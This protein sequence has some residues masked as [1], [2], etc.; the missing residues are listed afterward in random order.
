[1]AFQTTSKD[2]YVD[3]RSSIPVNDGQIVKLFVRERRPVTGPRKPVLMLHGRSVPAVAGF[4]P[5]TRTTAG[6]SN[7]P[8][9]ATTSS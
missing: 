4:D 5:R 3:H 2:H 6:P 9:R 8:G 1:M 7:S